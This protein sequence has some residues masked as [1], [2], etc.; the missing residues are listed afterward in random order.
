MDSKK[1]SRLSDKIYTAVDE[2]LLARDLPQLNESVKARKRPPVESD[3]SEPTEKKVKTGSEPSEGNGNAV[4]QP[5]QVMTA[6]QIKAMMANTMKQIEERKASIA[7]LKGLIIKMFICNISCYS[8][9]L[10]SNMQIRSA[11]RRHQKTT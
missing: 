4:P 9:V 8:K 11:K 5:V 2:F 7:A 6:A 3:A 10:L 1:A